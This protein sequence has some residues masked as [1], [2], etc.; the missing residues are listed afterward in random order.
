MKKETLPG[1]DTKLDA[2]VAPLKN[3]KKGYYGA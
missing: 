3:Y 2:K 1:I